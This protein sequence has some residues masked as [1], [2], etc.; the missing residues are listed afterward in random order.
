MPVCGIPA[1]VQFNVI[2]QCRGTNCAKNVS[3]SLC[4]NSTGSMRR[5]RKGHPSSFLSRRILQASTGSCYCNVNSKGERAQSLL[6]F[7]SEYDTCRSSL[8][9]KLVTPSSTA[10]PS[11]ELSSTPS[12]HLSRSP[13]SKPSRKPGSKTSKSQVQSR[14]KS[15]V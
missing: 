6:D 1:N 3:F 4:S 2:G 5:L 12:A 11:R 13:S 14:Q 10:E 8:W 15:Q 9:S 7:M